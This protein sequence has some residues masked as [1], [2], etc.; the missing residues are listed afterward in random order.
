M[1]KMNRLTKQTWDHIFKLE[2]ID[3]VFYYQTIVIPG[4]GPRE[5]LIYIIRAS[6]ST[7]FPFLP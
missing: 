1:E 3:F 4:L 5:L 7:V 6:N 2:P